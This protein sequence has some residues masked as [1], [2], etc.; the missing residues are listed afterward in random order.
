VSCWL[1]ELGLT[2]W[3]RFVQMILIDGFGL[4]G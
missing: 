1:A 2:R 4:Q 3:A